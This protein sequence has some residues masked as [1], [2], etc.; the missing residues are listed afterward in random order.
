LVSDFLNGYN[1]TL[2]V[3]GQT[4]SGK[5]HTMFGQS[6]GKQ[7]QKG[8]IWRAC[9]QIMN[10]I[11]TRAKFGCN[12]RVGVTYIEIYGD[13]VINLLNEGKSVSE[14][15]SAAREYVIQGNAEVEVKSLPQLERILL[16]GEMQKRKAATAMNER[17]SRAHSLMILHLQQTDE[18]CG[19]SLESR[20]ILGDLG[21]AEQV[22][23]SQVTGERLRETIYI[24]M[25]LLALK[26]CIDALHRKENFVPYGD[27]QLTKILSTALGGN[28]KTAVIVCASKEPINCAMTMQS[29][30]FAERCQQITN[31]AQK[32][33]GVALNVLEGLNAEISRLE[34]L[35]KEK[36]VWKNKKVEQKD[37]IEG[38]KILVQSYLTGAEKE[39][40]EL[41]VLLERRRQFLG[42]V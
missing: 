31:T 24:N 27:S 37:A 3:Y 20:L 11:E 14:N 40:E 10:K 18:E 9:E 17:S 15:K 36:E 26:K 28:S 35:I 33:R 8:I 32:A 29:L 41:E 25:G 21:G 39:R 4:G 16:L 12:S 42:S 30:R 34:D 22:K 19:L 6:E 38:T 2:F 23:A 7:A 13:Q 1:S 5:T